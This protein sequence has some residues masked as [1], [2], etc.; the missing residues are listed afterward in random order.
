VIDF[1]NPI[2]RVVVG[3]RDVD[4]VR[5]H[6]ESVA[7]RPADRIGQVLSGVI[8]REVPG[9]SDRLPSRALGST[10][11]GQIATDPADQEG[12]KAL[13]SVFQFEL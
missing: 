9:A 2:A 8:R 4:L 13:Q 12:V 1:S 11:G 5:R 10:G 6:T 7:L 3:Q